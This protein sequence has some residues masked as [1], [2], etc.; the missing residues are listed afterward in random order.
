MD[1]TTRPTLVFLAGLAAG[2]GLVALW[3]LV[4]FL[5]DLRAVRLATTAALAEAAAGDDPRNAEAAR[6]VVACQRRLI[7]QPR[8]RPLWL[9]PLA[10]E[11][12]ALVRALAAVYYPDHPDPLWAPG[13]SRFARA[14]ALTAEDISDFLEKR[15]IG[16]L[17]D[18][19]ATTARRTWDFGARLARH[20]HLRA[21]VRVYGRVQP[22]WQ[23]TRYRSPFMWAGLGATNAAV[24]VLQPTIVAIVARR[25]IQLYSGRPLDPP[26]TP[27]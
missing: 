6:L 1:I 19:S 3:M 27:G 5:L 14:L 17:M 12:P 26:G 15:R 24:R 10:D 11:I 8:L 22:V 25:A 7:F 2:L 16:R 23:A 4:R 18:V 21:A 9:R 20:Q 13:L